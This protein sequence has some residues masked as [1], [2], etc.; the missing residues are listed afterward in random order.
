MVSCQGLV[1]P[2]LLCKL[3]QLAG[4]RHLGVSGSFHGA[5]RSRRNRSGQWSMCWES[6]HR[7]NADRYMQY[8]VAYSDRP[9]AYP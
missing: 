8:Q 9:L 1:S 2:I 3:M 4:T 7:M 5:D 6:E